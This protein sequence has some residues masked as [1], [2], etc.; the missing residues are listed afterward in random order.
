MNT[1]KQA[2]VKDKVIYVANCVNVL[3]ST[4]EWEHFPEEIFDTTIQQALES[5]ES[6][7]KIWDDAKK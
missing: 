2:V 3:V 7:K 1:T 6:A 5:L 4:F